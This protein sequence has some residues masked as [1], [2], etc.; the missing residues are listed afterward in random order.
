MVVDNSAL[1]AIPLGEPEG[2]A[3]TLALAGAAMPVICAPY[4]LAAIFTV[5][6]D[7][8]RSRSAG[9]CRAVRPGAQRSGRLVDP[10][11]TGTAPRV[12]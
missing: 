7:D 12:S 11:R 2:D 8:G 5:G 10:R 4:W 1:V 3:L 9:F 6:I